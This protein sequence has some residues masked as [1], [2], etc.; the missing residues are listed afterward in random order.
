MK[1]NNINNEP[2]VDAKTIQK[3]F[4]MSK[5]NFE[6]WFRRGMPVFRIEKL[7]RFKIS[8]VE[9]WLKTYE[10]SAKKHD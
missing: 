2:W 10:I 4:A 1:D 6:I 7:R 8:E 9:A 5:S 3:Y